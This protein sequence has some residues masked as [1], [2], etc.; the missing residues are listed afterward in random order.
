MATFQYLKPETVVETFKTSKKYTEGLT[1]NFREYERIALNKPHGN[2][3]KEYPKTTDGTT[4]SIIRKTPHR[5][6]QQ[7][8]TGMVKNEDE[9]WLNVVASF[10]YE[11]EIIPNANEDYALLQKCWGV[12]E[13]FLTFGYCATYAPFV[14]RNGKFSTD[15]RLVY[16][17]D[18][19]IQPGKLSD[20][21]SSYIFLRSWWQTADIDALIDQQNSIDKKERTWDT[22]ALARVKENIQTKD[23]KSKTPAERN[24]QVNDQGGIELITGFQRGVGAKFYTFHVQSGE[25]VRTKVNKDPRGE[26]PVSFAYGDMDGSNPFGRSVIDL[27]GS[28]QNL[29][30]GEMQ[31]YQYNRALQL[32]PPIIKRGSYS[33]NQIKFAPNT[34]IDVGSDPNATAEPLKIDTTALANFPNNYG[35][36]K[37]QL[38]NLL[39]SPDTSTSAEVGNPGFSKTPAGVQQ[40]QANVSVDDNYVRKQ[41]E[42]WFERWSETAINTYFAERTGV[43]EIQLD[44]D[45]IEDLKKLASKN[46][47]DMNKLSEDGKLRIDFTSETPKLRFEVDASTSQVQDDVKQLQSLQA[48][49]ELLDK[50]PFLQ[51]IVPTDKQMALWNAIVDNSGIEGQESLS[52]DETELQQAKQELEQKKQQQQQMEQLQ[53]QQAQQQAQPPA[54]ADPTQMTPDHILKADAQAH[55]Q[56]LAESQHQMAQQK[57]QHDM[58]MAEQNAKQQAEQAKMQAQAKTGKPAPKAKPAPQPAPAPPQGVPAQGGSAT[59]QLVQQLQQMGL[60]DQ[61]IQQ[62]LA[63]LQAGYPIQEILKMFQGGQG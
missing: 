15:L 31:M 56:T 50:S 16:W 38:L 20:T 24:Q 47:F 51:Q 39:S 1:F 11:T 32:N 58:M 54:Q 44:N 30:D 37:S 57:Q 17:G 28:L 12:V 10:I 21:D 26:M 5:I 4:A 23:E 43:E 49:T 48:L 22:E 14:Q 46:K 9:D 42:T 55:A 59:D 60:T 27:V 45:S 53:M 34:I 61:Q 29:I 52:L 8:P 41:F 7:L 18:V 2:V 33:K 3:P 35:L 63:M 25:V 62:A 6:I 36:M 19:F 40:I 13:R